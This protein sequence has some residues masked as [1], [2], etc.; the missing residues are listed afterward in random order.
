[1]SRLS[2]FAA[3]VTAGL[4]LALAGAGVNWLITPNRHP[5]ASS[6]QTAAVIVQVIVGI[7][8]CLFLVN[9]YRTR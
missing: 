6:A 7:A 1:M 3:G 4:L 8:G 2:P 9:R 5:T